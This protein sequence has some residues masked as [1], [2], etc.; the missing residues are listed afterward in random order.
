M[1]NDPGYDYEGIQMNWIG[2]GIDHFTKFNYLWAQRR[3]KAG[4]TVENLKKFVFGYLGMPFILQSDNG[5]EFK[6]GLLRAE[7]E[8]WVGD[9]ELRYGRARHPQS[10]G[11]VEQANFTVHKQLAAYK[12]MHPLGFNWVSWLPRVMFNMNSSYIPSI[13][14]TP[15]SLCYGKEHNNG[16]RKT[17]LDDDG[18]SDVS[19]YDGEDYTYEIDSYDRKKK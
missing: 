3:K 2:H 16:S 5:L 17:S 8:S 10:Q 7:V 19:D 9:V 18:E 13:A 14:A 4:E 1:S 6:N 11:L 15:F 12:A